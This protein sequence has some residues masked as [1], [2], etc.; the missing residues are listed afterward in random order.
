MTT[1]TINNTETKS[2]MKFITWKVPV[3]YTREEMEKIQDDRV[4]LALKDVDNG[5]YST[6]EEFASRME[7]WFVEQ[8][9][10][11]ESSLD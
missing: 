4:R 1:A 6:H 11:Y 8:K 5:N 2:T 10:K 7:K 9:Q 3:D